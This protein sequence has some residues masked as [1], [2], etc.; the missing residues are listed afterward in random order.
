[1]IRFQRF[2]V[3]LP[4]LLWA[5]IVLPFCIHNSVHA[6][7][8]QSRR[9]FLAAQGSTMIMA[10]TA[11]PTTAAADNIDNYQSIVSLF[12]TNAIQWTGPAW[13]DSRYRTST[14]A[15]GTKNDNAAPPTVS[16]TIHY[17]DW[18]EGY[19]AIRYKFVAA[20]FPQGRSVP[21]LRTAG[22]GLGSC[23]SIPNIGYS[24]PAAH[25]VRY[26]QNSKGHV[27]PDASYNAPRTLETFWPKT[28]VVAVQINGGGGGGT[29]SG[30]SDSPQPVLT[31]KCF[32]MGEGCTLQEN[33]NLH[34]P[35][36]RVV[37]DFDGPTRR[38]D[39]QRQSMDV[40][41]LESFSS[42]SDD[43]LLFG[44]V[45]TYSQW[46]AQQEL[47]TFYQQVSTYQKLDTGDVVGK[48]RVAAFLPKYIQQMDTR[49]GGSKDDEYNDHKA[50]AI[51]DYK[52]FMKQIDESEA[53]SI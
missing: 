27:Y 31:P 19:F 10:S 44:T 41:L 7:S 25:A 51:Y 30:G 11:F 12:D 48:L 21:S 28:K 43:K 20:K 18:I 49:K 52:V 47:Q 35:S 15:L 34:M 33:P 39:S 6:L 45:Q 13:I 26:L 14:L 4:L 29:S 46:N 36:S 53:A 2:T 9:D 32:A 42:G 37:L 50:V 38:S 40:T 8:S 22:E 1:M 24:P 23:L 16:S 17:P 5:H 3:A